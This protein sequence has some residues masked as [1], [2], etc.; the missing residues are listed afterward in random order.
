MKLVLNFR[1]KYWDDHVLINN[2][3]IHLPPNNI[4]N[5]CKFNMTFTKSTNILIDWGDGSQ[6]SLVSSECSGNHYYND[7]GFY[8]LNIYQ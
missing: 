4:Y 1:L 8:N 6:T 3:E 7:Y 2:S 5:Y